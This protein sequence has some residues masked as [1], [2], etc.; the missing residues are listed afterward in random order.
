MV[1]AFGD[2]IM[3]D[4]LQIQDSA[5]SSKEK[6]QS[7]FENLKRLV[8]GLLTARMSQLHE[9]IELIKD[10]SLKPLEQCEDLISEAIAAAATVMEKGCHS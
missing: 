7:H 4:F 2:I 6:V 10:R 1:L 9:E 5:M 3:F 8:E